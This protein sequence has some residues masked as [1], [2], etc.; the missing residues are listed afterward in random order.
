MINLGELDTFNGY[1]AQTTNGRI[2]SYSIPSINL[3][4]CEY[5]KITFPKQAIDNEGDTVKLLKNG[6]AIYQTPVIKDTKNN[7]YFWTNPNVETIC[8]S[9][10]ISTA[11]TDDMIIIQRIQALEERA[12][13]TDDLINVLV[14]NI[15]LLQSE[16]RN[17]T[18]IIMSIFDSLN[19]E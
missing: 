8:N 14:E 17:I 1:V 2:A 11:Q 4:T 15:A 16:I 13:R 6:V 9:Q 3:N 5:H 10:T 12:D 7:N 18:N 19:S